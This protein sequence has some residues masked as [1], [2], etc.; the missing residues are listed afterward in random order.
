MQGQCAIRYKQYHYLNHAL[1]H[2]GCSTRSFEKEATL[3]T[4]R[5]SSQHSSFHAPCMRHRAVSIRV[6]GKH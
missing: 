6:T 1:G 3:L 4:M 2:A 5:C